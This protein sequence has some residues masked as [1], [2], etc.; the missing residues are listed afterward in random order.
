MRCLL[1]LVALI[2]ATPVQSAEFKV[3]KDTP[4]RFAVL[5]SGRTSILNL[6]GHVTNSTLL[7]TSAI[8][9]VKQSV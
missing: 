6:T 4:D 3:P 9:K 8:I 2:L 5:M 1:L 7:A